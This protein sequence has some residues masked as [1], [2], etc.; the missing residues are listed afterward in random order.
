MHTARDVLPVGVTLPVY[1]GLEAARA[2]F[3]DEELLHYI[4]HAVRTEALMNA[5]SAALEF[6][7]MYHLDP[8]SAELAPTDAD[9]HIQKI[10]NHSQRHH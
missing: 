7:A 10:D 4:N 5:R 9:E 3:T 2:H 8:E 1:D 6:E